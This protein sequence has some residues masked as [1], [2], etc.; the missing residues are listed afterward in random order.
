MIQSGYNPSQKI[1]E[2]EEK[3]EK[4]E[5]KNNQFDNSYTL[6]SKKRKKIKIQ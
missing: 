2:L 5:N 3:L 4:A 1:I 6:S